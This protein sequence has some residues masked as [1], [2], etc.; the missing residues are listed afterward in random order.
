MLST[1][2]GRISADGFSSSDEGWRHSKAFTLQNFEEP[3]RLKEKS[4]RLLQQNCLT[5]HGDLV[6]DIAHG[7]APDEATRCVRCHASVGHGPTR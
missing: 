2:L 1:L 6:H 3:I 4:A 7:P 5:C